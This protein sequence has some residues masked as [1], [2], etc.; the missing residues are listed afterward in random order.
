[1]NRLGFL[2][3]EIP[4]LIERLKGQTALIPRSVFSHLAG[5]DDEAL[6]SF[7]KHQIALFD[8]ASTLLYICV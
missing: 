2:P 6:D 5:S 4:E 8:G 3:S 7:T 1:M